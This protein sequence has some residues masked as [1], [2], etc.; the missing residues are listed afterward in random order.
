METKVYRHELKFLCEEKQLYIIEDR[1]RHI[2]RP[3][4][5]AGEEGAYLVRSLYFDTCDDRC[6]F[7]NLAGA[8]CRKK[9]RIRT[10]NSETDRLK[11]EC[12]YSRCGRK[13]KESCGIDGR[14]CREL[15]SGKAL[16]G[17]PCRAGGCLWA[18]F[19]EGEASGEAGLLGRFL[20]E[21]RMELLEPKAVVEYE[22][23]P[24]VYGAGNVRITFDRKIRS[25]HDIASF[26]KESLSYRSILPEGVHV[27]EV[28]YDEVLPAAVRELLAAGQELRRTSFSKYALCRQYGFR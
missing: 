11:L 3:D 10:Y 18:G 8:D 13:R 20:L 22:R 27:L 25:S 17:A 19:P 15:A 14:Q 9:Y 21:R 4:A 24:Y 26:P 2:C 6:Y 7:E 1:I 16:R 28:K 23:R 12:K 5:H